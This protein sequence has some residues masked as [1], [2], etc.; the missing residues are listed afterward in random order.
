MVIQA[1]HKEIVRRDTQ[2]VGDINKCIETGRTA[3]DFNEATELDA[4]NVKNDK[5]NAKKMFLDGFL[6][7]G[8]VLPNLEDFDLG[9]GPMAA[10]AKN[11]AKSRAMHKEIEAAREAVS[12]ASMPTDQTKE[13]DYWIYEF[14]MPDEEK[15]RLLDMA[16][17]IG[18][19]SD[20]FIQ[21]SFRYALRAA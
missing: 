14:Q 8:I 1:V 6:P 16:A 19:T 7:Y 12:K 5:K 4:E 21:A 20:Q 18:M 2:S 3:S 10:Q 15:K 11:M 13:I 17:S 9:E